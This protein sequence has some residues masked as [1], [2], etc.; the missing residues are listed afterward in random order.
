MALIKCEECG[1]DVS[2][3]ASACPGC[4][5]PT[6]KKSTGSEREGVVGASPASNSIQSSPVVQVVVS[7]RVTGADG[8]AAPHVASVSNS[9]TAPFS[10]MSGPRLLLRGSLI[11][12]LL[13]IG[14]SAYLSWYSNKPRAARAMQYTAVATPAMQLRELPPLP[15]LPTRPAE[16][17]NFAA[18]E[19]ALASAMPLQILRSECKWDRHTF[20]KDDF[21]VTCPVFNPRGTAA[22]VQVTASLYQSGKAKRFGVATGVIGINETQDIK[23]KFGGVDFSGDASCLCE[24]VRVV[25]E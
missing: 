6:A 5:C 25:G 12:L 20:G 10:P 7:P 23:I 3:K 18:A 17:A 21:W 11:G 14:L 16:Q 15:E 13:V 24:R 9:A 22:Q 4:G 8:V 2:N 1:R 19:K